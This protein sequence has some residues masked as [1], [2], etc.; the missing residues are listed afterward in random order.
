[1]S[2]SIESKLKKYPIG[3]LKKLL[4]KKNTLLSIEMEKNRKDTRKIKK[5]HSTRNKL[6]NLIETSEL[7]AVK[8]RLNAENS[9]IHQHIKS[10]FNNYKKNRKRLKLSTLPTLHSTLK[11]IPTSH[12][13]YKLPPKSHRSP[14]S[15]SNWEM[16]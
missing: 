15:N 8:A 4:S 5:I 3:T 1:M 14:K 10:I 12:K 2:K 7:N 6:L 9:I 16:V 13:S 11:N